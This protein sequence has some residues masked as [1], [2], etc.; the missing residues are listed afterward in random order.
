MLMDT[1]LYD[2]A[3]KIGSILKEK[4]QFIATAESCTGGLLAKTLTD[5]PGSSA[6]FDRGFITYSNAAKQEDLGV[7]LKTLEEFGA[8]SEET[9]KEMAE[10]ALKNNHT[11]IGV[12]ITGIA[13][14]DGGTKDKPV[15]S[16]C[17]AWAH[18]GLPTKTAKVHFDGD[19]AS[20]RTQAVKWALEGLM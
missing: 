12:A 10:G 15:G 18:A 1:E 13:G 17:V 11:Q 6:Y 14:P 19:R 7:K 3:K 5:V 2:L 4:K 9:A 16:V 20:I 8:V